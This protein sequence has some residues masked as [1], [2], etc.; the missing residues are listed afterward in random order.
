MRSLLGIA[1]RVAVP[2][3]TAP[4]SLVTVRDL[5]DYSLRQVESEAGRAALR[6]AGLD[7]SDLIAAYKLGYLPDRYRDLLPVDQRHHFGR[8]WNAN[9]IIFPA[10]DER[11][12]IVDLMAYR[13]E[14]NH[15][16]R[17]LWPEPQGLLAPV[18][19]TAFEHLVVTDV[20]RRLGSLTRGGTPA[21][22]LRG[23]ADARLN[24]ARIAAGGVRSV[25]I[26]AHRDAD[27]IAAA[28][29][30][31][32]IAV[33]VALNPYGHHR[34][35]VVAQ[36][37]G[38]REG[39]AEVAMV[40]GADVAPDH[41]DADEAI[42]APVL[43][44][45]PTPVLVAEPIPAP[46][47]EVVAPVAPAAPT[48]APAITLPTL[49]LVEHDRQGERA[50]FRFGAGTYEVTVPSRPTSTLAVAVTG[51]KRTQRASFDLSVEE[52]RRRNGAMIALGTGLAG[53]EVA[54]ALVALLPAVL[55]LVEPRAPSIAPLNLAAVVMRADERDEAMAL[56]K[57][58]DLVPRMVAALG[59]LGADPDDP[60]TTIAL[61]AAVSRL[62]DRPMWAAL[63][64]SMPSERFPALAAIALAT[65][66]DQVIHI[67]RLSAE[68]LNH[69]D[70]E[71]LRHRLLI[72]GDA[73]EITDRAA[74]SLRLL[75]DRGVI[76]TST[77][78]R[79][80]QYGGLRTRVVE[81]HGPIAVLAASTAALPHGLDHHL[82]GVPVD[83]SPEAQVRQRQASDQPMADPAL[84][85]SAQR[86]RD[87][88][89]RRM[90]SAQRLLI[91]RPVAIPDL[92]GIALPVALA[93]NRLHHDTLVGLIQASALLHQHQ[94]PTVEGCVVATSADTDLAVH[95]LHHVAALQC[96]GISR[97]AHRMLTTLWAGKRT[98][99]SMDDLDAVLPGWT[100]WAYRAAL[101]E[102]V[103]LDFV[104]AGRGGR[105]KRREYELV[106][107]A[108][109]SP[110]LRMPVSGGNA[111][112]NEV[113]H[114]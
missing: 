72:L 71:A 26:H 51:P 106:A 102:L 27:A 113:A 14:S 50:V 85:A 110:A 54:S 98:R 43:V 22:L 9:A 76:A 93:R 84:L 66:A 1:P 63:T 68:A 11:G 100:R 90:H 25:E 112:E 57:A 4:L 89:I 45:E 65:P 52:A 95:L 13:P 101:A 10:F 105:G 60:A 64:A 49:A 108:P 6:A 41:V 97:S 111:G 20:P 87:S 107:T 46:V 5:Y 73:A 80:T 37:R 17:S 88:A 81:V 109:R 8:D 40:A 31:A 83:D 12:V 30:A 62:A 35:G 42:P 103:A 39:V 53:P 29:T 79:S 70:P 67:T 96:A 36:S 34:A 55:A 82:F 47:V 58:G 32:G 18:L 59:A 92:A 78:E 21:L 44:V 104:A 28:F 61:L 56:L 23:V 77:V 15:T 114:G 3:S 16:A 94:R 99:F 24:A 91:P 48:P 38:K 75:H 7:Q 74:T 69:H 86:R 19:T 2:V 33:Q